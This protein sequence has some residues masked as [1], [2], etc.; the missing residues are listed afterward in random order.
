MNLEHFKKMAHSPLRNYALPGVTSY[1][2]GE[3]AKNGSM[4]RLFHSD[5]VQVMAVTPHSH[6]YDFEAYV[7]QGQVRNRIWRLDRAGDLY[8][9][10]ELEYLGQPGN[11]KKTDSTITKWSFK[12]RD[13][14]G[15]ASYGMTY[16]QVHSIYFARDTWV[17]VAEGP[18]VSSASCILEPVVDG[19]TIE[20]SKT[21][22][23]MFQP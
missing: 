11:Y 14:Y 22:S 4:M 15:G 13:Y 1:L 20:T 21:E 23:W 5:R 17:L 9:I 7:L 18:T 2:I 8:R 3:R 12:D 16:S 6:R 10:I 19:V